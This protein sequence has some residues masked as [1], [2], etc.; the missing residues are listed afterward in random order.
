MVRRIGAE[1]SEEAPC[2]SGGLSF[3]MSALMGGQQRGKGL[4]THHA[5][6][7]PREVHPH[8]SSTSRVS[9]L[10]LHL[11]PPGLDFPGGGH[12]SSVTSLAASAGVAEPL[13]TPARVVPG[14]HPQATSQKR[15]SVSSQV[16]A[17]QGLPSPVCFGSRR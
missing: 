2:Y 5:P 12:P 17:P 9:N 16:I 11:S 1:C 15:E 8:P 7:A 6:R 13:L 3:L 4:S 10:A 14:G